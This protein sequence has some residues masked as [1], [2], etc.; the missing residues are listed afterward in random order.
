MVSTSSRTFTP[1]NYLDRLPPE[2]ID[3]EEAILGAILLDPKAIFRVDMLKSEH[4]YVLA[5]KLIYETFVKLR[6]ENKPTDLISVVNHLKDHGLL[7]RVGGRNKLAQLLNLTVSSVNIEHLAELV[8]Q[9]AL[10]RQMIALGH[11]MTEMPYRNDLDVDDIRAHLRERIA[12]V[13]D[14]VWARPENERDQWYYERLLEDLR[15]IHLK[16]ADPGFKQYKLQALAKKVSKTVKD[17]EHIYHKSLCANVEP[18]RFLGQIET[19]LGTTSRKWLLGGLI[20]AATTILVYADG[21]VGKTKFM[22]DL[23]YSL[24]VG[25][26]WNKFPVTSPGR[27][28]LL[29]QGDES[30]YD[31]LQ[32]LNQRGFTPESEGRKQL[33]VRFGWN[34]DAMPILTQDIEE[35]DPDIIVIDSLTF[36]NR[37]SIYDENQV[38]YSRPVLE[39]NQIAALYGKTIVLIHHANRNGQA[40][41]S[42]AIRNAVSEVLKLERDTSATANPQEKILTIEKSRA[43]R[44]PCQYRLFFNEEDFSLSVLGEVGQE[45]GSPDLAIKD[46]IVQFLQSNKNTRFEAE[47]IALHL[48]T[49]HG[50]ARRCLNQL[51]RD[52]LIN[53]DQICPSG[54]AKRYYI[55]F[56]TQNCSTVTVSEATGYQ[57]ITLPIEPNDCLTSNTAEIEPTYKKDG[58]PTIAYTIASD[59]RLDNPQ[60]T[61]DSDEGDR[62]RTPKCVKSDSTAPEKTSDLCD[63]LITFAGNDCHTSI[64]EGDRQGDRIGDRRGDRLIS[65]EGDRL[66]DQSDRLPQVQTDVVRNAPLPLECPR[67]GLP[68][69]HPFEVSI[70][71]AMGTSSAMLTP[72]RIRKDNRIEI[73]FDYRFANG[74]T[75]SSREPVGGGRDA[76]KQIAYEEIGRWEKQATS[77]SSPPL[78]PSQPGN[79]FTTGDHVAPVEGRH[80][81]KFF[82]ITT[83]DDTGIWARKKNK[84]FSPIVGPFQPHQLK[85]LIEGERWE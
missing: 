69:P 10:R 66:N 56:D 60:S 47:E 72:I 65:E 22:Y 13:M 68:L 5:H 61:S 51:A 36:V 12:Y 35:F 41:G 45:L 4:F 81:G 44:F 77:R 27:R 67:T 39:L 38:E 40:R 73:R 16:I 6:E 84:G 24:A 25:E 14:G 64:S 31:M 3:A 50:N 53:C 75:Y 20:P 23:M 59:D 7:E 71:G 58:S 17:L 54:V 70:A 42:T 33:Q 37:F 19:E 83:I 82:T 43:R 29:Y 18:R 76:A 80:K 30:K 85:K 8:V 11:E 63:R 79:V 15:N 34:V 1:D 62:I 21:G 28:V 57:R 26:N 32:A 49:S 78:S 74:D 46:R 9:K 48:S 55:A 2:N 52:G